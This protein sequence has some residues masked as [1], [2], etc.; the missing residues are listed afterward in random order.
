MDFE[1]LFVA[2]VKT[3]LKTPPYTETTHNLGTQSF[4]EGELYT[5]PS[6]SPK[7]TGIISNISSIGRRAGNP[8]PSGNTVSITLNDTR[9]SYGRNKRFRDNLEK[10]EIIDQDV[11]IYSYK[12]P[13]GAVGVIADFKLEFT[14]RVTGVSISPQG[15]ALTIE[16]QSKGISQEVLQTIIDPNGA[17]EFAN[18][19]ESVRG[20]PLPIIFGRSEALCYPLDEQSPITADYG[21]ATTFGTT[22]Q[23]QALNKYLSQATGKTKYVEIENPGSGHIL[24]LGNPLGGGSIGSSGPDFDDTQEHA[25]SFTT[26]TKGVLVEAVRVYSYVDTGWVSSNFGDTTCQVNIYEN[27]LGSGPGRKLAS[28]YEDRGNPILR[29]STTPPSAPGSFIDT[30]VLQN[31]ITLEPLTTYWISFRNAGWAGTLWYLGH[32]SGGDS[33]TYWHK[34]SISGEPS[35]FEDSSDDEPCYEFYGPEFS[36]T[37]GSAN[38]LAT[39]TVEGYSGV[40][41]AN[42]AQLKLAVEV[43]GLEDD[44]SGTITGTV[45]KL[46]D[47]SAEAAACLLSQ[48]SETYDITT[49]DCAEFMDTT[50]PRIIAGVSN[51]RQSVADII[52]QILYETKCTSYNDASGKLVFFPY[53]YV[54]ADRQRI[55]EAD[56][57]LID[58][59]ILGPSTIVTHTD[60]VY[61]RS[62]SPLEN[63][64]I[65]ANKPRNYLKTLEQQN[66]DGGDPASWTEESFNLFGTKRVSD[67]VSVLDWIQDDATAS[68][69]SEFYLTV[70]S[71]PT[72]LV[73]IEIPYF[74]KDYNTIEIMDVI[75]IE[76]V[77]NPNDSGTSPDGF[78]KYPVYNGVAHEEIVSSFPWRMAKK[79][80]MRVLSRTVRDNFTLELQLKV[81][82]NP[83]EIY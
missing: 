19:V 8:I 30:V 17:S 45:N 80:P 76:H 42:I 5:T 31:F 29:G 56:C 33:V 70:Y 60:F 25:V 26:G 36:A 1:R 2:Q 72:E 75:E 41:S 13:I 79:Y 50:Y 4:E 6:N 16:A 69:L 68:F 40:A 38:N 35:W 55:S 20:R 46:L 53:G 22:H 48:I 3:A 67:L 63:E 77:D 61:G 64:E 82:N 34:R 54:Q 7:V 65:Q 14:G 27:G 28:G 51:G 73:T 49:F 83:K 44:N 52:S 18:S 21:F 11:T 58:W 57:R 12:K 23:I 47:N 62:V 24:D 39:I 9:D 81:L 71:R 59:K 32:I 10:G 15:N 43:D 78:T 66:A 74:E 37:L